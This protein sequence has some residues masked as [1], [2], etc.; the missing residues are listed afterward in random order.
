[1][2]VASTCVSSMLMISNGCITSMSRLSFLLFCFISLLTRKFLPFLSVDELCAI[3]HNSFLWCN[4]LASPIKCN[5]APGHLPPKEKKKRWK[6][7]NSSLFME[8]WECGHWKLSAGHSRTR[9]IRWMPDL[10]YLSQKFRHQYK[11][12]CERSVPAKETQ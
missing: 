10:R 8:C 6:P 7:E 4:N 11:V 5:S 3:T 9:R 1:M 2:N 12:P